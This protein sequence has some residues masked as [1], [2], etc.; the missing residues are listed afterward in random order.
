MCA[1][2]HLACH[3]ETWH[4]TKLDPRVGG[5]VRCGGDAG[6]DFHRRLLFTCW[7]WRPRRSAG[8]CSRFATIVDRRRAS[9]YIAFQERCD[10]Q[11]P[12]RHATTCPRT[13]E[14]TPRESE[15][16]L[17]RYIQSQRIRHLDRL[18]ILG[19]GELD[20]RDR[21]GDACPDILIETPRHRG[22]DLAIAADRER[23][24]RRAASG[25]HRGSRG[26]AINSVAPCS[27]VSEARPRGTTRE[28]T[29]PGSASEIAARMV[30]ASSRTSIALGRSS[31]SLA[32]M[33]W[34]SAQSSRGA[35]LYSSSGDGSP[36]RC[37][38]ATSARDLPSNGGRPASAS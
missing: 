17:E 18:A 11:R 23:S 4:V 21:R 38:A 30:R 36:A 35:S 10:I 3:V 16:K 14:R 12:L 20:L 8:V 19:F 1:L 5:Q 6:A 24:D 13:P 25:V 26:M 15:A 29:A 7:R 31:G 32:S 28:R 37:G 33:R 2:Q 27:R 22:R 34:I 9:T